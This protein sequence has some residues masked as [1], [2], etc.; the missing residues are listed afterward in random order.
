[1]NVASS[2]KYRLQLSLV[3]PDHFF[4]LYYCPNVKDKSGLTIKYCSKVSYKLIAPPATSSCIARYST[5]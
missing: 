1:M 2:V 5:L 3:Y 4:L